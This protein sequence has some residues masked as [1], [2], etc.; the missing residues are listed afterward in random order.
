MKVFTDKFKVTKTEDNSYL[1]SIKINDN[2]V[3]VISISKRDME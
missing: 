1:M 2:Q 3:Q